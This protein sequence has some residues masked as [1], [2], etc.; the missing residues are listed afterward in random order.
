MTARWIAT[1]ERHAG[2]AAIDA[3]TGVH[4]GIGTAAG[5]AG[6]DPKMALLVALLAEGAFEVMKAGT[7]H[8]M[9]EAGRGQSKINEIFDLLSMV[10][11]AYVG[12]GM[13]TM[14]QKS[15][16]APIPTVPQTTQPPPAIPA[17]GFGLYAR[18]AP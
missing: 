10:T 12:Q 18:G 4:F 16:A 8:A 13:R 7:T 6:I 17:A 11:G 1:S 9:F 14:I 3:S 5:L 2:T 15:A